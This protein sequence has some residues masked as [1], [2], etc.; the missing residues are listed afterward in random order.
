MT[1][2]L[3]PAEPS[4][5]LETATAVADKPV[6]P[7]KRR[8]RVSV[9]GILGE[10]LLTVGVAVLLFL[11]WQLFLND[12][13]VGQQLQ[14]ESLEQSQLWE[15]NIAE[16][17][18]GEPDNPPVLDVPGNTERFGLLIVPRFGQD[19]YRP[20]AEGVGAAEVLNQNN[21]GHYPGTQMPGE[22]GNFAIAAHRKAYGGNL[23]KINELQLGDSVYVETKDGWYRYVFR[24]L[25]YVHPTGVGVLDPVPQQGATAPEDRIITLTSC[26]PLF[27]VD[28]RI[29]AYGVFDRFY[30]RAGGAP[31]E[32]ADT[33]RAIG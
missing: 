28:E 22:P 2:E 5:G 20:I 23:E 12:I 16:A 18:P 7:A 8:R 6:A 19:Y 10:L 27:S 15:K 9:V 3:V 30:E 11:G 17:V 24:N 25:E 31:E 4:G 13:I 29:I 33:I 26:N 32:I 14:A 1:G 21:F